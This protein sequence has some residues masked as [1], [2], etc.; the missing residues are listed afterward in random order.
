MDAFDRN[1]HEDNPFMLNVSKKKNKNLLTAVS[2]FVDHS[3]SFLTS[4]FFSGS[5]SC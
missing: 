5:S 4:T 2:S 3:N 1:L